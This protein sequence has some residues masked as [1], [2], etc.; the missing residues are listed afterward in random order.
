MQ[1]T[2]VSCTVC[3]SDPVTHDC[4]WYDCQLVVILAKPFQ[5]AVSHGLSVFGPL[6]ACMCT[7][8][9]LK[10]YKNLFFILPVSCLGAGSR[11][12]L[13]V[14]SDLAPDLVQSCS[15][16]LLYFCEFVFAQRGGGIIS[17]LTLMLGVLAGQ[18]Y[19]PICYAFRELWPTSM[20]IVLDIDI[21]V[22]MLPGVCVSGSTCPPIF[23]F[24]VF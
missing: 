12:G 4:V 7:Q 11:S 15:L 1:P 5:P 10:N 21:Y 2:L 18:D 23:D 8:V 14:V 3:V 20:H 16:P 24:F 9:I 22:C 17:V 6:S 13:S 19:G